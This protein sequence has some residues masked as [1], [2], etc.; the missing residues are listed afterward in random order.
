[1][2]TGTKAMM[3][4]AGSGGSISNVVI[5]WVSKSDASGSDKYYFHL[6]NTNG[7]IQFSTEI[8]YGAG[9]G[10]PWYSFPTTWNGGGN[11]NIN[12]VGDIMWVTA[13]SNNQWWG[14]DVLTGDISYHNNPF[15]WSNV[16]QYGPA[17]GIY[18]PFQ[19]GTSG[20]TPWLDI[21][22]LMYYNYSGTH[23]QQFGMIRLTG[24]RT[25]APTG[26]TQTKSSSWGN[27]A[28]N[29]GGSIVGFD[30]NSTGY[31]NWE[32][33]LFY[34]E[35]AVPPTSTYNVKL[36]RAT[37]Q[38]TFG[39]NTY[40][41]NLSGSNNYFGPTSNYSRGTG[42]RLTS[43]HGAQKYFDENWYFVN[44]SNTQG[45][46]IGNTYQVPTPRNEANGG[47]QP[48]ITSPWNG[49]TFSTSS[50]QTFDYQQQ[51]PLASNFVNGIYGCSSTYGSGGDGGF[52]SRLLFMDLGGTY[53]SQ[54]VTV[55]PVLSSN[56]CYQATANIYA[57]SAGSANYEMM[58]CSMRRINDDGY[59]A[60]LVPDWSVTNKNRCD[61]M[62]FNKTTQVG[63]TINIDF[64][65]AKQNKAHKILGAGE[66][67]EWGTALH[68]G[69]NTS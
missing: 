11:I 67:S 48:T 59:M 17:Y 15:T 69:S 28:L 46:G 49:G 19:N 14:I 64:D 66:D 24:D 21:G 30:V 35:G 37:F 38:N 50:N 9:S 18:T 43:T 31:S 40:E 56:R 27:T 3:A 34:Q 60:I 6:I 7:D 33:Q 44:P 63:S 32:D 5:P 62:I 22:Q 55:G 39:S 12:M 58:S 61:L 57:S 42:V 36:Y 10:S 8:G 20:G 65:T 4:A 54:S 41:P 51:S 1:M 52:A 29:N 45:S 68:T 26:R 13:A 53:G 47:V 2:S 16:S 23:R 25:V